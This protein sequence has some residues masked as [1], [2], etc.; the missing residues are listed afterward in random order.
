MIASL[1]LGRLL[2]LPGGDTPRSIAFNQHVA[3]AAIPVK[4]SAALFNASAVPIPLTAVPSPASGRGGTAKR[5]VRVERVADGSDVWGYPAVIGSRNIS[6]G[7]P[8]IYWRN[9]S[10][11]VSA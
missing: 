7:N 5:W 1:N 11:P 8:G 6:T 3:V 9:A 10:T 4:L 2:I